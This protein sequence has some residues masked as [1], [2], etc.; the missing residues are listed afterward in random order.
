MKGKV[1]SAVRRWHRETQGS[2]MVEFAVA[3]VVFF[4]LVCGIIDLGHAYFMDQVVTNASREG[5]RYGITYQTDSSGQR[6]SPS[7]LN[8]SI[9]SYVLNQ[10]LSQ[11]MLPADADPQV[12]VSGDGYSGTCDKGENLEVTVTAVKSWI[13]INN[14]IP[15]LGDQ[16]TLSATTVMKCE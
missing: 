1:L 9:A 8:P 11:T 10:Y 13:V 4:L 14:F 16:I 15:G 12:T 2:V 6:I 7:S 3:S 5:A